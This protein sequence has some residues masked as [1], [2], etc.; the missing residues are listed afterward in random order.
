MPDS[1]DAY[2]AG[3]SAKFRNYLKRVTRKIHARRVEV[4]V[5]AGDRSESGFTEAFARI[6][7]IEQT[8]WKHAHGWAMSSKSAATEFWREVCR[9]AW[10]EGRMHVQFLTIDGRPAAYN[11]GYIVG[12]DYAY[13]K[14]TFGSEFREVGAATFLRA[15][16][17]EDLIDRGIRRVDFPGE[18]YE[19]GAAVDRRRPRTRDADGI[20]G[21]RQVAGAGGARAGQTPRRDAT[22]RAGRPTRDGLAVARPSCLDLSCLADPRTARIDVTHEPTPTLYSTGSRR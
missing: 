2:L 20:F 21:Y 6:L 13:L 18:P 16:L 9:S 19:W 12:A 3:R 17:V 15:R 8:S 22:R 7:A 1:L 5:L 11:L 14:T 4:T 10:A